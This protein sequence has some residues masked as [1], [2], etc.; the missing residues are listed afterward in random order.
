MKYLI[1]I[2]DTDNT[3]SHGTGFHARQLAEALEDAG[4]GQVQGVTRHLNYVHP[5]IRYTSKNSSA[6]LLVD[7]EQYDEMKAFCRQFLLDISTNGGNTG[8]C[9][10]DESDIPRL[11]L[12]WG[13]RTKV[14]LLAGTEALEIAGK[15][16]GIYLEGLSGNHTGIIGAMAAVGLRKGGFDGR[17]IWLR[18]QKELRDLVPGYY[19]PSELKEIYGIQQILIRLEKQFLGDG[20]ILV[21]DWFRPVLKHHKATLIIEKFFDGEG[22]TRWKVAKKKYINSHS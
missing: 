6:C 4:L 14:E 3:D 11:V 19:R 16:N 12:K 15:F 8:L 1:G 22:K 7:T 5:A 10:A 20:E 21:H 13:K 2:D 18:Q 9:I 17:F